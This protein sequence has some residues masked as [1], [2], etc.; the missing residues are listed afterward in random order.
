MPC[1]SKPEFFRIQASCAAHDPRTAL[2]PLAEAEI[3]NS[4]LEHC[5]VIGRK[6]T[7]PPDAT[8]TVSR[9]H[10]VQRLSW[11]SIPAAWYR[12]AQ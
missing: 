4:A 5:T 2:M 7:G 11:M 1:P 6:S 10:G 3:R 9:S 12:T 8:R